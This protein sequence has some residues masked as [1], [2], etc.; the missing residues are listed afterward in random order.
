MAFVSRGLLPLLLLLGSLSAGCLSEPDEESPAAE[1]PAATRP[2]QGFLANNTTLDAP[3]KSLLPINYRVTTATGPANELAIAV[4]PKNPLNLIAGGKDYFLGTDHPCDGNYPIN[5]WTGVYWSKDG[6]QT[7]KNALMPGHPEDAA[8]AS[9]PNRIYPCNSDPVVA[10]GSDGTAYFSGLGIRGPGT[11]NPQHPCVETSSSIW[12]M[13][14][15]DG[16]D[17]WK[18]WSCVGAATAPLAGVDKQWF[19]VDGHNVYF[20]FMDFNPTQLNLVFRRST[21]QGRTWDPPRILFESPTEPALG[22]QFSTPAVG[23]QGEVY[24]TW[25]GFGSMGGVYFTRSLDQ[26]VTFEAPRKIA[27]ITPI[28]NNFG[29][30][31]YRTSSYPVLAAA[32][33]PGNHSGSLYVTWADGRNGNPDVLLIR[34]TDKGATW[35][36]PVRINND[37]TESTARQFL[38]WITTSPNND[39][40]LVWLDDRIGGNATSLDAFYRV[41]RDGGAMWDPEVRLTPAS[42]ST[43]NCQHQ[44]GANFIGDYIGLAASNVAV[45]PLWPD[46]RNDRCDAYTAT[47]LR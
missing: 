20:T 22:R 32:A 14:S 47:L 36:Q 44:S 3:F 40:H 42:F 38:P 15:T 19:V 26:G 37:T 13:K 8:N 17:T 27:S 7:W 18:D 46:G 2:W 25:R 39:V 6:G 9:H 34:S 45:H 23:P 35:S 30:G 12:L 28:P 11:P 43:Q 1:P 29:S 31:L 10:F 41:S 4:N 16:G 21:D 33:G 24:V 5:V